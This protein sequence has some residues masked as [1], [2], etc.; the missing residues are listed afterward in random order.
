MGECDSLL[1]EVKYHDFYVSLLILG[2]I[3]YAI[4]DLLYRAIDGCGFLLKDYYLTNLEIPYE[5]RIRLVRWQAGRIF[6]GI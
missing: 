6:I 1:E 5:D 2:S 3:N 4:G